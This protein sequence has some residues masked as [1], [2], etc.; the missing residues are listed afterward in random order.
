MPAFSH[1]RKVYLN[2][3]AASGVRAFEACRE[4]VCSDMAK[5]LKSPC[6]TLVDASVAG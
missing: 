3:G 4:L 2:R 6:P 5:V 1:S